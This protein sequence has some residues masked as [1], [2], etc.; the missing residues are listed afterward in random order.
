M[1]WNCL[2]LIALMYFLLMCRVVATG[3]LGSAI[4]FQMVFQTYELT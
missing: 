3:G 4:V 2:F 1:A